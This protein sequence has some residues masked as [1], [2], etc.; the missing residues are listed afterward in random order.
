LSEN[1]IK[2]IISIIEIIQQ[3]IL[4]YRRFNTLKTTYNSNTINEFEKFKNIFASNKNAADREIFNFLKSTNNNFEDLI[5]IDN[6]K[7]KIR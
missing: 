6:N 4:H 3:R 5:E 7:V 1:I 2:Y